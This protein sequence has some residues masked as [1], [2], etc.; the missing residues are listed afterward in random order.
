MADMLA[1]SAQPATN[2]AD[3]RALFAEARRRRRRRR[4][5]AAGGVVVLAGTAAGVLSALPGRDRQPARPSHH[6][7]LAGVPNLPA[8]ADVVAWVDYGGQLHIGD[9]ATLKQHVLA[10]INDQNGV[11]IEAD[12]RLYWPGTRSIWAL[13]VSTGARWRVARGQWV[14]RS[15]DGRQIYIA[16]ADFARSV[17]VMPATGAGHGRLVRLPAGWLMDDYPDVAV[18]GGIMVS[19]RHRMGILQIGSGRVRVIAAGPADSGRAADW[20]IGAYTPHG[21]SYSLLAWSGPP[22]CRWP[23]CSVEI[24]NTRTGHTVTVRSP[25]RLGFVSSL[26]A[27]SFAQRSPQL[28]E[29][30]HVNNPLG[31]DGSSELAIINASTGAVRLD[32]LVRMTTTEDAAWVIWLPGGSRLLAGAIDRSFLAD[33]LTLA[34]KQFYFDGN[35]TPT[36]TI[37]TSPDL[38][39]STVYVPASALSHKLRALLAGPLHGGGGS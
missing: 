2:A 27:G 1:Q 23:H 33:P 21:A 38:N 37:M 24:T 34:S 11:L 12:G 32:P 19:S 9:L 3:V 22:G 31:N 16:P 14:Q 25:L 26:H 8:P 20:P 39:F 15:A 6:E 28:A 18:A 30:V 13:D 35:A 10:Q 29:F 7:K 5:A 4:I 17:L 36:Q